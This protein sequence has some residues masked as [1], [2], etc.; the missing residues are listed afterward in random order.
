LQTADGLKA[1]TYR[2]A[3]KWLGLLVDD[4]LYNE[5]LLEASA[6]QTGY[7]LAEMFAM[8]CVHAP[9]SDPEKL[10]QTHF[11]VFTDD[12]LRVDMNNRFSRTLRLN[13]RRVLGLF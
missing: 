3:C 2:I 12:C 6:S 11:E 13:E 8:M 9:P 10:F 1:K 5:A 7:Q 4:H